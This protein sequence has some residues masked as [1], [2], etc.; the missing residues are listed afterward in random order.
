VVKTGALNCLGQG[1][2]RDYRGCLKSGQLNL[3]DWVS[4]TGAREDDY[5]RG[6]F[7]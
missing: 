1:C 4:L 6:P 2:L 7:L 5:L 3:A